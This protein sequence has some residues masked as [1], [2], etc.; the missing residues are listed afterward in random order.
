MSPST[1]PPPNVP[2]PEP[3]SRTSNF[4]PGFCGVE[5]FV[6]T[7]V[8]TTTFSPLFNLLIASLNTSCIWPPGSIENRSK[9][10]RKSTD[11]NPIK[12]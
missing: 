4:A 10:F 2:V 6:R 1:H 9:V 8:A 5:P 11:D 12:R 3:S 7:T